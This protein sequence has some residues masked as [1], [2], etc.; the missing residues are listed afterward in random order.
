MDR[1]VTFAL[2]LLV[3]LLIR[4]QNLDKI[5]DK[6]IT[7]AGYDSYYHMRLAKVIV[8]TG[9]RPSFDYYINYPYGL[10]I[11]WP[12]LYDYL[13][14]LPGQIAG[15]HA[16]E[17]FAVFLPP[18]LGVISTIL[19]YLISKSLIQNEFFSQLSALIFALT[20]S[21]V[22]TSVA[23]FS[24]YHVWNLFLILLTVYTIISLKSPYDLLAALPL[25]ALS[26]S[27][28]G[29]PIY[30]SIVAISSLIK[31]DKK[32]IMHISAA[33]LLP[34]VSYIYQPF[35]GIS[36][37][38]L[39]AF[40]F[41]GAFIK[42]R[43]GE[44]GVLEYSTVSTA[45]VALLYFAPLKE[46]SFVKSGINYL[47]GL[48]IYLPTI[49]EAK[50]FD[51]LGIMYL[52]GAFIFLLSL[53][54]L[55]A[56]KDK[57]IRTF[58]ITSFLLS[59]LQLRFAEIL[60]VPVAILSAYTLCI[61]LE[62]LEYPIFEKK[63]TDK[64]SKKRKEPKVQSVKTADKAI[65]V[66]FIGFM[67]LPSLVYAIRPLD[68]NEDWKNALLWVKN[69]TEPTS[70]YL[71]PEN[72]PEYAIMSWWDYGNWIVY[73]AERPVVCNNFQAG[74]I[75]A[76]KFFTAQAEEDAIKIAKKRGVK[77]IITD[78]EMKLHDGKFTA[79][80]RIAGLNIVNKTKIQEF[81]NNSIYYKL[82]IENAENLRKIVL[83]KEFDSVKVFEI[84][85]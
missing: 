72:K 2:I 28:M 80:M 52:S 74:A 76:A 57:F 64:K 78:D 61:T 31:F 30:A 50:Q 60:S 43:R 14:S 13:I 11:G 73:V 46:L 84:K 39:S 27:W 1:R 56:F 37:V 35:M 36:F 70:N 15:F 67:L 85:D 51:I 66:I 47:L 21:V 62:R 71:L 19:V 7:F 41:V 3:S 44:R 75:D 48:S 6:T 40:L 63:E 5:L 29:A 53:P 42:E 45:L 18:V 22:L 34:V 59:L 16:T 68:I 79:I 81:Y 24:D 12:P 55:I 82:H 54:G 83:I 65:V 69:N 20:P 32:K 9:H 25:A 10:K 33:F 8:S 38:I 23:G 77:Y 26:F 4:M 58:F 49:A 17:L